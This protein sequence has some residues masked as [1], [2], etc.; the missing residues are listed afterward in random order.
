MRSVDINFDSIYSPDGPIRCF[1]VGSFVQ[2]YAMFTAALTSTNN[3]RAY[4]LPT[5]SKQKAYQNE[6]YFTYFT[7]SCISYPVDI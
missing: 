7:G 1:A 3:L 4:N 5:T 2:E 6:R